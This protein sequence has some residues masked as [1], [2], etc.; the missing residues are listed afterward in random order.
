LGAAKISQPSQSAGILDL[1]TWS[2]GLLENLAINYL[3]QPEETLN[4]I[5]YGLVILGAVVAG[6]T[7][8]SKAELARVPYFT[9]SALVLLLVSAVQLVWLQTFPAMMGGYLWVLMAISLAAPIVGG[10]FF[11]KLA[12]ARSRDAY[13]HGRMAALAFIPSPISG[14]C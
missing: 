1:N 6:A 12:M 7:N 10:Y 5:G 4:A 14:S 9:Y 8:R 13:G 2:S 11:G 3:D